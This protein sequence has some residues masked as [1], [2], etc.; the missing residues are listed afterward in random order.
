[1]KFQ[2]EGAWVGEEGG[3]NDV[4]G[5]ERVDEVLKA[6]DREVREDE[7]SNGE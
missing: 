1:M 2:D 5:D 4:V 7:K 3:D 6:K